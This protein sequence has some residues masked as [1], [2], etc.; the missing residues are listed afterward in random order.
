[1][2]IIKNQAKLYGLKVINLY[3]D[4]CVLNYFVAHYFVLRVDI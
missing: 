3:T 1:M 4:H 2:Q